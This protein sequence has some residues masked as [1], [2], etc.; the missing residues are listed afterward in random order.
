MTKTEK[1]VQRVRRMEGL[2]DELL[3]AGQ[4][5]GKALEQFEKAHVLAKKLDAYYA[6]HWMEDFQADENGLLPADLKRGVLSEDG[7]WNALADY[8]A[9]VIRMQE[10]VTASFEKGPF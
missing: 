10:A 2:Y 6:T 8:R 9:L 4:S 3:A 5:L 1:I 7:L